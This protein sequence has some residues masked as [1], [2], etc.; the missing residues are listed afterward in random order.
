[1]DDFTALETCGAQLPVGPTG[2][3]K[4][5]Q[6]NIII[7]GRGRGRFIRGFLKPH[8]A[9]LVFS[10]IFFLLLN[11]F[12]QK[13]NFSDLNSQHHHGKQQMHTIKLLEVMM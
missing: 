11:S 5:S 6:S 12:F 8:W 7:R 3:N 9:R 2:Y 1:M 13:L 4:M 10:R